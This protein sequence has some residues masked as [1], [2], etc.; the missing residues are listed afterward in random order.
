MRIKRRRAV[1]LALATAGTLAA[2][3]IALAAASSTVNFAFTC[4]G[5]TIPNKCPATTYTNGRLFFHAHTNYTGNPFASA[6]NRAQ[7]FYDTDFQFRPGATPKC[8]PPSG[9]NV[10]M[11]QAMAACGPSL[12]GTGRAQVIGVHPL[13][14]TILING[15][16]L[17]FNGTPVSAATGVGSNTASHPVIWLF[18]RA[19]LSDPSSIDCSSP[20]TNENG[21]R[22]LRLRGIV[23]TKAEAPGAHPQ[24]P[25]GTGTEQDLNNITSVVPGAATD[26]QGTFVKNTATNGYVRGRC[27]HSNH[28]WKVVTKFTY[29]DST[30]QTVNST[31]TCTVG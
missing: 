17:A 3:G 19:Q 5:R 11:K 10:T 15:C 6:V 27:S 4:A 21:N 13:G 1:V 30:T 22:S 24:F 28:V 9:D 20:A 31:R 16:V 29:S 26:I 25:P 8:D 14:G 12:V 2:A 18:V 7:I 23:H